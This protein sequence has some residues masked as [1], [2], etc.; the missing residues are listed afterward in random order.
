MASFV[1]SAYPIKQ[2]EKVGDISRNTF[3][4]LSFRN[5]SDMSGIMVA[6]LFWNPTP[7]N[8][9]RCR[10]FVIFIVSITFLL[11]SV[12]RF[13]YGT[14]GVVLC[15]HS[16]MFGGIINWRIWSFCVQNRICVEI[17]RILCYTTENE[18][19]L[20]CIE[21]NTERTV[22]QTDKSAAICINS[23]TGWILN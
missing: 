10:G 22:R 18:M 7:P 16:T 19:Q 14:T 4:T 1:Q 13:S 8:N 15:I 23:K 17:D 12:V 6:S 5:F 21:K 20:R 9:H 11:R 2:R 3:S